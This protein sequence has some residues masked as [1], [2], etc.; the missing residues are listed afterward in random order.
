MCK[1]FFIVLMLILPVQFGWAAVA[2]YCHHETGEAAKHFGHHEHQHRAAQDGASKDSKA[3][4]SLGADT[5]C[6][7]CHLSAAQPVPS[8]ETELA[9][10]GTE[11]PRFAYVARY[12]SYIPSGP[13]RPDRSAPMP[14]VRFGGVVVTGALL[15]A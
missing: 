8:A 1:V 15:R 4:T 5:D 13:E 6:G 11:A 10:V 7:V 2:G 9:I 3:P 14:A 12:D